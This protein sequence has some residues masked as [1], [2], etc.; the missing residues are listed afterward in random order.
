MADIEELHYD[1][2]TL[3]KVYAALLKQ[4][5]V[6]QKAVDVVTD[7]EKAGILFREQKPK[8]R[9]RPP[10]PSEAYRESKDAIAKAKESIVSATA[11]DAWS[12]DDAQK[13]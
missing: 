5:I 9:G 10:K 3:V 1:E 7:L 6:G 11:P 13:P 4:G 8:R 2:N 12:E